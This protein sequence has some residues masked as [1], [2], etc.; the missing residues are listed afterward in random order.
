[1]AYDTETAERI[2]LI[3][4][5]Q[6]GITEKEMFG[7]LCFLDRG[8]MCCGVMKSKIVLRL[9]QPLATE[10]LQMKHTAPMDFTGRI[11]RTMVYVAPPGYRKDADL[12]RWIEIALG[13]TNE[14]DPKD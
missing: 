3:L 2:R 4:S 11:I 6:V 10:A 14:L 1:M 9:G 5:N 8:N 7:G 13:F 12:K